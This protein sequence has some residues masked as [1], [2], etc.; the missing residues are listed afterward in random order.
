MTGRN[1]LVIMTDEQTRNAAG[2]YGHPIVSTPNIDRLAARGTR[3]T[4]A[5]TPSPICVPARASFATGTYVHQN[6][7]WSNAEAYAGQI[8]GWGHRLLEQGRDCVSVGKLHYRS[9]D[10]PNGFSEEINPLYIHN[11]LGFVHGLL[12]R[13]HLF[14]D[15]VEE[16]AEKIGPG[17]DPYTEYDRGVCEKAKAWL[18]RNA[19]GRKD[20]PWTMFVSFLRPHYPMT[21]PREF[22]GLYPLDRVPKRR[23]AGRESEYAHPVLAA[24]RHYA[25]YDDYFEDDHQRQIARASYLGLCSFVDDLI[26]QVLG[27]LE[28][29]GQA[30]E[31]DILFTSDHGEMQGDHG[32]W[33][34][35][36]M[37]EEA[38]GI[39]MI[40][41]GPGAPKGVCNTPVSL[42]DVHKTILDGAG[43]AASEEDE[44]RPGRSL[45]D[46]ARAGDDRD[47]VAFSE[48][49]DCGAITGMFMIRYRNWKY[50]YYPGFPPQLFD[51]DADMY[52]NRD[53]AHSTQHR[54][55]IDVCHAKLLEICDPD[56]VNAR[57]FDDQAAVIERLG[58]VKGILGIEPYDYTPVE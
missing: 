53:L 54:D 35:M 7:C 18:K 23:Y 32:Y 39:P 22:Y 9:A 8:E 40:L 3:F 20:K 51:M 57:C 4:R 15:G 42:V 12:R 29:S 28:D 56:A 58:G 2:C 34:K 55:V 25:N 50:V 36:V 38:V 48:Y 19:A 5:Y 17:D 6:G 31:T 24:M 14:F 16:F 44:K 30:G 37:Y 49:H 47:R 10:D 46:V 45:Y 27:A 1:M 52:E 43:I 26:G 41:S 11:G 33:T 21:C 13:Q